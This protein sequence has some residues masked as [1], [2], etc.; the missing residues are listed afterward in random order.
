MTSL[1][2][3]SPRGRNT[4]RQDGAVIS[5]TNAAA[6]Q[7]AAKVD[8]WTPHDVAEWLY[9]QGTKDDYAHTFLVN[10]VD[11]SALLGLNREQLAEWRVKPV[12]AT[13]I[14]KGV[15]DLNRIYQGDI[16]WAPGEPDQ[17]KPPENKP[18]SVAR[19]SKNSP[20]RQEKRIAAPSAEMGGGGGFLTEPIME[21]ITAAPTVA[22]PE[23]SKLGSTPRLNKT[24]GRTSPTY[25]RKVMGQLHPTSGVPLWKEE[26]VDRV[27]RQA[28]QAN[29]RRQKDQRMQMAATAPPTTRLTN[30]SPRTTRVSMGNRKGSTSQLADDAVSVAS[31]ALPSLSKDVE[32]K[33][34]W[35]QDAIHEQ[36]LQQQL[37]EQKFRSLSDEIEES[38]ERRKATSAELKGVGTVNLDKEI[39]RRN[40]RDRL[41][42]SKTL[43]VNEERVADAERVNKN[44]QETINKL[45][46]ARAEFL[47]QMGKMTERETAMNTDM[48]HFAQSAHASL[49][50]KEKLESKV[51]RQQF[52]YKVE[53]QHF[54]CVFQTLEQ[55]VNELDSS[56]SS[57]HAAE[58][59]L[60]QQQRQGNYRALKAKRN[61]DEKREL[62]LGYLQNNV[63]GQEM[64]FQRL[65]RI[66]G[67]KFTPEKP[68]S[69]M[70]I[71]ACSLKHEQ[72]NSSLLHFVGVQRKEIEALQAS[73]QDLEAEEKALL[74]QQQSASAE[75]ETKAA[76]LEKSEQMEEEVVGQI[77]RAN[78]ILENLCPEVEN[79]CKVTGATDSVSTA[80]SMLLQLKGCRPDSLPDFLRLIDISLRDL[81]ARAESLPTAAGNEWLRDFLQPKVVNTHPSVHEI[82]RDIEVASQKQKEGSGLHLDHKPEQSPGEEAPDLGDTL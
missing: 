79:L 54:E 22:T 44:L 55:E 17:K 29:A 47:R 36:E 25:L 75:R 68:E 61:A 80:D 46:K 11:G 53:K 24:T 40:N 67:V 64:D 38:E 18:K 78:A 59:E 7:N 15:Q 14:L 76:R 16:G 21:S 37:L 56:I 13:T 52:D 32:R 9:L 8:E 4:R 27:K 26:I 77:S 5:S 3:L 69:V 63:R 41:R 43:Q 35:Y 65:H 71:V 66:M 73:L 45:R 6:E 12:D 49:D 19:S 2:V 28:Q 33:V 60:L 62:K 39:N 10:Q 50:E 57:A 48:K 30:P 58:E 23:I 70:E 81:R 42:L 72:R 1:P 51:K 82:R 34:F 74:I 20:R 31:G